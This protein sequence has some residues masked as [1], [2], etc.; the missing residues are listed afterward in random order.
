MMAN[1]SDEQAEQEMD[2]EDKTKRETAKNMESKITLMT[3]LELYE[4]MVTYV[5]VL[6]FTTKEP[7]YITSSIGIVVL[8]GGY[9][10]MVYN[11]HT[12]SEVFGWVFRPE[13]SSGIVVCSVLVPLT[14]LGNAVII[15][16]HSNEV[17]SE[18]YEYLLPAAGIAM[19]TVVNILQCGNIY[20]N[21][22]SRF[23]MLYWYAMIGSVGLIP[24]FGGVY[25]TLI[26]GTI[27]GFSVLCK[28]LHVLPHSFT[29][30]EGILVTEGLVLLSI[31][32]VMNIAGYY[33]RPQLHSC[34]Q[35]LTLGAL[36]IGLAMY[37]TLYTMHEVNMLKE[38]EKYNQFLWKWSLSFYIGTA[39][40]ILSVLQS[41]L[42][43]LLAENPIL[44]ALY[45]LFDNTTRIF[46]VV[47]WL[48][49]VVLAIAI[50]GW[51]ST[52]S[53]RHIARSTTVR[54]CFHA[55]AAI[56]FTSGLLIDSDLLY[57][58]SAGT[59]SIF[60]ILEYMRVF[61]IKPF[62][63]ILH[64]AFSAFADEKDVGPVIL[65]HIYLLL[66][67]SLP[68]WLYPLR[69]YQGPS[70]AMYSGVISLGCGDTA[71]SLIGS[72]YKEI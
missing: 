53:R 52:P 20:N 29:I 15:R 54:K 57:L 67:F 39:V 21:K 66:G 55:V 27:T 7:W 61:R 11:S 36:F 34:L 58:G 31:D 49:L 18:L 32:T 1:T 23:A 47:V 22:L 14:L 6:C 35:V 2:G 71:A 28:L 17:W 44:F 3:R 26:L 33:D 42:W 59:F 72:R 46:L 62:G 63:E 19:V 25:S 8:L 37:P 65:T 51:F 60:I 30:G 16:D 64:D 56:I 24:L 4:Y 12:L 5:A 70:I 48:L 68:V 50:V 40:F 38:S 69:Y 41:W 10:S 43:Y 13:A 9:T 45:F